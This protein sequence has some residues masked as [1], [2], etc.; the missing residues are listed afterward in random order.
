MN[1]EQIKEL[2]GMGFT[3]EQIMSLSVQPGQ[4]P[5]PVPEES[6]QEQTEPA[7]PAEPAE[8][9]QPNQFTEL[10]AR[11]NEQQKTIESLTKQLQAQNRKSARID[12][13]P[14]DLTAQ[15]DKIMAELIRPTI[16]EVK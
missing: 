13:P 4:D 9:E 3:A 11:L 7:E 10:E 5:E 8:P 12:T 2:H 14:D 6:E 15:T 1:F 16:K